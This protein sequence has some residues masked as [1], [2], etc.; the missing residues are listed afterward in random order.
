MLE[1]TRLVGGISGKGVLGMRWVGS[2][3]SGETYSLMIVGRKTGRLEKATL[4]LK[5][6]AAVM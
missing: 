6:M 4:Q 2:W 3:W 5:N 1:E